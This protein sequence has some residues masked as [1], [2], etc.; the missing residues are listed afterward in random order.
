MPGISFLMNVK[1]IVQTIALHFASR[2]NHCVKEKT[3]CGGKCKPFE[4]EKIGK[5]IKSFAQTLNLAN[6]TIWNV[7]K[8]RETTGVLSNMHIVEAFGQ[9]KQQLMT[10]ALS[11]LWRQSSS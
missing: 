7:L 11:E 2:I 3:V 8:N 1:L 4:F 9:G 6:A 5:T 10:D